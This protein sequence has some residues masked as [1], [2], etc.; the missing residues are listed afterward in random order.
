MLLGL[1]IS[2]LQPLNNGAGTCEKQLKITYYGHACFRLDIGQ[3]SILI[4][5]FDDSLGFKVKRHKVDYLM[6]SHNHFDHNYKKCAEVKER[7]FEPGNFRDESPVEL[8]DTITVTRILT[9]HDEEKGKAR[10]KNYIHII[11]TGKIRIAHLG[12]LGHKLDEETIRKLGHIDILLIPIG[13]GPVISGRTAFRI[14]RDIREHTGK[15]LLV[16]PMH[17]RHDDNKKTHYLTDTVDSFTKLFDADKHFKID[18][19]KTNFFDVP[20][21]IKNPRVIVLN[22]TGS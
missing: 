12:D 20:Q 3:A 11:D 17:Y 2:L 18:R 4:D 6:I 15:P 8:K 9:F 13:G 16:L 7:I 14:I 5:P 10:G 22:H 1:F 19:H 21:E